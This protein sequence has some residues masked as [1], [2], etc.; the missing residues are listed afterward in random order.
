MAKRTK[1]QHKVDA[2]VFNRTAKKT[3]EINVKPTQMRGGIRL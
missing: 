2:K 3:K 1:L